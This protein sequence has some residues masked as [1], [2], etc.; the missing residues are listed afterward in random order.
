MK[1]KSEA[2]PGDR[3]MITKALGDGP[4][5]RRSGGAGTEYR[6]LRRLGCGCWTGEIP[7]PK[8]PRFLGLEITIGP[9]AGCKHPQGSLGGYPVG[10]EL[11]WEFVEE[12]PPA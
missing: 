9:S 3:V 10:T 2:K 5:V 1:D 8:D 11:N 7:E 12:T 6:L 4:I